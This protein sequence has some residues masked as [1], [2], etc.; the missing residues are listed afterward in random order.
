MQRRSRTSVMIPSSGGHP[1]PGPTVT[2]VPSN[3]V[4]AED[5]ATP[6]L[7]EDGNTFVVSE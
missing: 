2:A 1:G 3:A 7:A 5:G 4:V 6:I